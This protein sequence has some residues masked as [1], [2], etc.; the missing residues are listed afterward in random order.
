MF[1]RWG[2]LWIVLAVIAAYVAFTAIWQML[3][4]I[5]QETYQN[6]VK[7]VMESRRRNVALC[8]QERLADDLTKSRKELP[9][10]TS[11]AEHEASCVYIWRDTPANSC[12]PPKISN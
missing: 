8:V 10:L 9:T 7:G 6:C 2:C 11:R 12:R 4:P 3:F 5:T 1:E